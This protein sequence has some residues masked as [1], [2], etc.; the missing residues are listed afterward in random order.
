MSRG[1]P[2]NE[3]IGSGLEP[4]S[5]I[6]R[7]P[8]VLVMI[9]L[10]RTSLWRRVRAGNFPGPVR[11]GGAESRAAGWHREDVEMWLEALPRAKARL[12]SPSRGADP[13]RLDSLA[14]RAVDP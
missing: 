3:P 13:S 4:A 7:T 8:T 6:L 9:G 1:S 10:S 12:W 14:V 2:F 11:L 5:V